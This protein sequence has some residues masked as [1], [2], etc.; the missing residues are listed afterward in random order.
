MLPPWAVAYAIIVVSTLILNTINVLSFLDERSWQNRPIDWW[1]PAVWE[2]SSAIVIFVI[3]W[4]PMLAVRHFPP[5]GRSWL[6]NLAIHA[7]LSHPVLAG[8]CHAD[9]GAAP[10]RLCDRRRNL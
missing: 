5:H 10:R 7:A 2:G 8:P 3:L 4:M 1:Q 6:R 9:G